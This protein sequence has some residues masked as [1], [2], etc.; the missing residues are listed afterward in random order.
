MSLNNTLT[1]IGA[2]KWWI[3]E[4][5]LAFKKRNEKRNNGVEPKKT[6]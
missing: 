1:S 6:S 2:T 5:K 4:L 3:E